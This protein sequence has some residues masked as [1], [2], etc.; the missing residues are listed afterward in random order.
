MDTG[1]LVIF[2]IVIAGTIIV[3][4]ITDL[5][6]FD[7]STW[8]ATGRSRPAW[9]ALMVAFGPLAVLL[10]WGTVRFDLLDPSR[11]DPDRS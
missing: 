8:T 1:L 2:S 10:Y 5:Y 6:R 11:L 4:G 9:T 3:F 7:R